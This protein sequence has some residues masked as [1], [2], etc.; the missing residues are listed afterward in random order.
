LAA[1]ARDIGKADV[2]AA[3]Q[4]ARAG[5]PTGVGSQGLRRRRA[6]RPRTVGPH[7]R[8]ARAGS[9]QRRLDEHQ[10]ASANR[11]RPRGAGPSWGVGSQGR[12]HRRGRRPATR[13]GARA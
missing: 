1:G 4:G 6:Q 7:R 10:I 2:S 12:R 9:L 13:Q 3:R 5:P 8:G 11:R